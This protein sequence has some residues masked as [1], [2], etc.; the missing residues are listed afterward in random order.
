[1]PAYSIL[2]YFCTAWPEK[3]CEKFLTVLDSE[4]EEDKEGLTD[5][6]WVD[7]QWFMNGGKVWGKV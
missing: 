5:W 1:M 4:Y 7:W 3:R 6:F 2:L